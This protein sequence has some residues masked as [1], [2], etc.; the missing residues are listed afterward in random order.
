MTSI[1]GKRGRPRKPG[2]KTG[3]VWPVP[4]RG[5]D[6]VC[7][8]ALDE[9]LLLCLGHAMVLRQQ[10]G[11]ICAWPDCEQSTSFRPLCPYHVKR[12]FGLLDGYVPG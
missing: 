3:C 10:V 2:R 7:G 11:R 6:G 9:G 12:A 4:G 5:G 1:I 8:E